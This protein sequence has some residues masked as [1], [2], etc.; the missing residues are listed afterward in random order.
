MNRIGDWEVLNQYLEPGQAQQ[1]LDLEKKALETIKSRDGAQVELV[2]AEIK[3]FVKQLPV[4]T[5]DLFWAYWAMNEPQIGILERKKSQ[6]TIDRMEQ[7]A[8][9]QNFDLANQYLTQFREQ[10]DQMVAKIPTNL[11]KA[12]RG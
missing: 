9:G 10:T 8:A 11:L 7:A 4:P 3:D 2:I 12:E 5:W 6:D 1:A